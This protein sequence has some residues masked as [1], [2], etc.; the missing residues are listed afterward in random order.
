M[1]ELTS[2]QAEDHV[3]LEKCRKGVFIQSISVVSR[4]LNVE[5]CGTAPRLALDTGAET[6]LYLV[7]HECL[8]FSS[9][10]KMHRSQMNPDVRKK[11]AAAW[12]RPTME[13]RMW[14]LSIVP[15]FM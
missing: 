6:G 9:S 13:V 14:H 3:M 10:S 5:W 11:A 1:V 12:D 2:S 8:Y 7:V 15:T 4:S